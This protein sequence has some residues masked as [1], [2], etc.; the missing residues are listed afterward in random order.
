MVYKAATRS[1]QP[2]GSPPFS[3]HRM[4]MTDLLERK[5]ALKVELNRHISTCAEDCNRTSPQECFCQDFEHG[6]KIKLCTSNHPWPSTLVKRC[7]RSRH[8]RYTTISIARG[9]AIKPGSRTEDG[10]HS[11]NF[12][13]LDINPF[14]IMD[15]LGSETPP[16]KVQSTDLKVLPELAGVAA[17][18]VQVKP[19]AFSTSSEEDQPPWKC[20][21]DAEDLDQ[22]EISKRVWRDGKDLRKISITDGGCHQADTDGEVTTWRNNLSMLEKM[23]Q[24]RIDLRHKLPY[25]DVSFDSSEPSPSRCNKTNSAA[26]QDSVQFTR[27]PLYAPES[28][29]RFE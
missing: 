21:Y 20:L 29:V 11:Q 26:R 16:V 28:Q 25:Q 24:L 6:S 4:V 18:E 9:F 13:H 5:H 15:H 10:L 17:I 27:L 1:P 3:L 19:E 22:L 12:V 23:L 7:S 8:E 14:R 2:R